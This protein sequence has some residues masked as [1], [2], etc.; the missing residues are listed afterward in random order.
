MKKVFAMFL[1]AVTAAALL[2]GCTGGGTS[3]T[4]ASADTQ[5]AAASTTESAAAST[6]ETTAE[7]ATV[8][9]AYMPDYA[10]LSGL[11]SAINLGYF[12][13]EGID[14]NLTEFADGPTIINAME[15][16][17]IDVGYIGQ[18]AHKLC[19]QGRADIFA[20]AHVSNGDAIIGSK[21]K[22]TDTLEGLKGKV[23]AYAPGTSSEDILELGLQKAGL[24]MDDIQP[25]SMDATNLVSAM[26]SGSVDAC[27]AWVP[28]T[29]QILK[30]MGDD[31]VQLCDNKMFTDQT[32]SLSSWICMPSYV[33]ENRDVLVRFTRALYKGFDYRANHDNDDTVAGWVADQIKGDKDTQLEQVNVADWTTSDFINND[34]DTV[35]QYYQTQQDAIVAAGDAEAAPLEDYILFDVMEEACKDIDEAAAEAGE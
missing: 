15:S 25:M 2:A 29:N 31:A 27:A 7:R 19:I 21:S 6:G 14:V 18:G 1:S 33:E 11:V 3:S 30:Q 28:N 32:V 34:M 23:V 4:T 35:K 10:S 16:G 17:S 26:I 20:L 9:V 22:G 12:D 24:T 8:N 5:S 13:E